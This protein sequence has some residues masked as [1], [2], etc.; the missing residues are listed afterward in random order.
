MEEKVESWISTRTSRIVFVGRVGTRPRQD[1]KSQAPSK[2]VANTDVEELAASS[3]WKKENRR[4]G[5]QRTQPFITICASDLAWLFQRNDKVISKGSSFLFSNSL[6]LFRGFPTCR[7]AF[8]D[9]HFYGQS[10]QLFRQLII[11]PSI[12]FSWDVSHRINNL[13]KTTPHKS[14]KEE[15]ENYT[16]TKNSFQTH[17]QSMHF[18]CLLYHRKPTLGIVCRTASHA[19]GTSRMTHTTFA[20]GLIGDIQLTANCR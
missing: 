6:S 10:V 20:V 12:A 13:E 19:P 9:L 7:H 11:C 4:L 3:I 8:S 16:E 17:K 15:D 2:A 14:K 5:K 18:F 1:I